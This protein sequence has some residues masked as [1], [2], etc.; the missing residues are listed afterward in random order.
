MRGLITLSIIIMAI[1]AAFCLTL[2]AWS[3]EQKTQQ[4]ATLQSHNIIPL[5]VKKI[6]GKVPQKLPPKKSLRGEEPNVLLNDLF[7]FIRSTYDQAGKQLIADSTWSSSVQRTSSEVFIHVSVKYTGV[8]NNVAS[9]QQ[10]RISADTFNMMIQFSYVVYL[11]IND[12]E[13]HRLVY[14]KYSYD[15]NIEPFTTYEFS[16]KIDPLF[17][18]EPL[19]WDE[20]AQLHVTAEV[21]TSRKINESDEKNNSCSYVLFLR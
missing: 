20:L 15:V 12:S 8:Q 13:D 16:F 21:D 11:P 18:K 2:T 7:C 19:F 14:D 6:S 4:E 1:L 10:R 5:G 9:L 17:F 3:D